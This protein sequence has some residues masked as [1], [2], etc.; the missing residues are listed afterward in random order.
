[1]FGKRTKKCKGIFDLSTLWVRIKYESWETWEDERN[2]TA[3]FKYWCGTHPTPACCTF[4]RNWHNKSSLYS[5]VIHSFCF[6]TPLSHHDPFVTRK[7]RL[8]RPPPPDT[9]IPNFINCH[10]AYPLRARNESPPDGPANMTPLLVHSLRSL[11]HPPTQHAPMY[12]VRAIYPLSQ[13]HTCFFLNKE[14]IFIITLFFFF[15]PV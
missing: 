9:R 13:E 1:M 8:C 6:F 7:C 5:L 15:L 3:L 11:T 2:T 10:K 14:Q 4:S 12:H